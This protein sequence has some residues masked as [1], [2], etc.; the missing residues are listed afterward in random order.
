MYNNHCVKIWSKIS[1]K[2]RRGVENRETIERGG[3]RWPL[4]TVET[5]VNGDSKTKTD[6]VPSLVGSLRSSCR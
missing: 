5:E 2:N 1:I 4:L 3:P 6:R